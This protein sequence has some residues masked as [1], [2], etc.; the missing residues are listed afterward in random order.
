MKRPERRFNARFSGGIDGSEAEVVHILIT[1]IY[2]TIRHPLPKTIIGASSIRAPSQ[3]CQLGSQILAIWTRLTPFISLAFAAVV[4]AHLLTIFPRIPEWLAPL[5]LSGGVCCVVAWRRICRHSTRVV[6][7]AIAGACVILGVVM[8]DQMR[9]PRSPSEFRLGSAGNSA[10]VTRAEVD[11][12]VGRS[13]F[14]WRLRVE[15]RSVDGRRLAEPVD[16]LLYVPADMA[17]PGDMLPGNQL[18]VFAE[19]EPFRTSDFP[20]GFDERSF[21]R[22]RGYLARATAAEAPMVVARALH[23]RRDLTKWRLW[24][25][26]RVLDGL[27]E[28]RAGPIL[29]LTTA[30]RGYMAPE[31]RR[32]FEQTGTAHLLAISGLH[33][34]ALAGLLWLAFG[35]IVVRVAPRACERYGR[36]RLC[37]VSVVI[38]LAAYVAAIGAP[39]SAVRAW[40]AVAIGVG[41]IVSMRAFCPLHALAAAALGAVLAQPSVVHEM[42]FQL[43]FSATLGILLFLEWRPAWL[44]AADA[45][46]KDETPV[47]K[48]IRRAALYAG[49]SISASLATW[50]VLLAHFGV[51]SASGIWLNLIATP[52]FGAAVFPCVV[53][54]TALACIWA[55]M[56]PIA[57]QIAHRILEAIHS[58]LSVVAAWPGAEVT[59]GVPSPMAVGVVAMCVLV[60]CTSCG[61][62]RRV[63]P[64]LV[65]LLL[66]LAFGGP[67]QPTDRVRVHF[68]PVGQ[69][70]ATLL[71]F[72]DGQNMLIDAG[73][74]RMGPDP[75]RRLV[76]PYLR[77]LGVET[78]EWLVITHS[79][80]DHLGG[81]TAVIDA[82]APEALAVD[83]RDESPALLAVVGQVTEA[84]GRVV[85]IA[86]ARK[87][88]GLAG[89]EIVRPDPVGRSAGNDRSLVVLLRRPSGNALFAGDIELIGENWLRHHREV[90]SMLLKIP[91]H[92]SR[93]SS[94]R[95]FLDAVRPAVAVSSSGRNH[96]FGHPHAEV[97]DRY[98][99]RGVAVFGT[100]RDGLVV[101]DMKDDGR[102]EV[103]AR[104][105]ELE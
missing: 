6:I 77:R 7:A 97:V 82:Y 81:A 80:W 20:H 45:P 1:I 103:R 51:V 15:A 9:S 4:C 58:V 24:L 25:E 42:G 92:G 3:F 39:V 36:R 76:V 68:I 40:F 63:I 17:E 94:S 52:V 67:A 29:A 18:E 90:R 14:G 66:V 26:N 33:L 57:L 100:H 62:L 105:R 37:G 56:A 65:V 41:A 28:A 74:R 85:P 87:P 61:R 84:G 91:H 78:L 88:A 99:R 60:F 83:A 11:A 89:V 23:W 31:Y 19:V 96:H 75:G 79:D 34:G 27:G 48:W 102:A 71:Q 21:Y 47:T 53:V 93:T 95:R 43:S 35:A 104:H 54:L 64:S 22:G 59:V 16:L 8:L 72:P 101:V 32:P 69:G 30:T 2:A 5:W 50:P 73:G 46:W 55:P 49:V 86:D 13:P 38:A 10:V 12:I 44:Q 98:T 70:D